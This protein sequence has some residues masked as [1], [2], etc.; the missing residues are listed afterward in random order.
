MTDFTLPNPA[1]APRGA[2][3]AAD[4]FSAALQALGHAWR[5]QT[6]Y[7]AQ[8]RRGSE[9]AALRR[10]AVEVGRSDPAF[11]ADLYSAADRHMGDE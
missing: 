4:V 2:T 11:A 6:R 9:A 5:A 10:Y 1:H 3:F 8:L 7:R